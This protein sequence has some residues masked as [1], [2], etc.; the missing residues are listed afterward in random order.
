MFHALK[1]GESSALGILYDRYSSLV[2]RLALRILANP[3]EAE[4]LTQEVFLTFWRS[5]ILQSCSWFYEQLF[6]NS[7]AIAGD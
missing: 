7:N 1:A 6:N 4:D 3:Q 5:N 2:Y